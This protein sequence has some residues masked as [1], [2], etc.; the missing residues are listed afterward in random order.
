MSIVTK[1]VLLIILFMCVPFFLFGYFWYTISA[2]TAE[3]NA[4]AFS[5]Q[6]LHQ[7]SE[8]LNGYFR[9][10]ER[11]TY[12]L[13]THPLIQQFLKIPANETY[14]QFAYT[15]RIKEELLPSIIFG[16]AD[17]YNFSVLSKQS[18][19]LSS[20]GGPELKKRNL[21]LL[22]ALVP[23]QNYNVIGIDRIDAAPVLTIMRVFLDT[24]SYKHTGILL[25]DLNLN[26]INNICGRNRLG[27][28][29][30]LWGIDRNGYTVCHPDKSKWGL[31]VAE[32]E[33]KPYQNASGSFKKQDN[34]NTLVTYHR[35]ENT[36]LTLISEVPLQEM[37]RGLNALRDVT[38]IIGILLGAIIF[39][40]LGAFAFSL[41]RSLRNLQRLMK[42]AEIGDLSVTAPEQP[43]NSEMDSV[44]RSFNKM[45]NEI[46]R[47]IE[48]VHR[49]EL[50]QKD[51]Q[52]R[53]RESVL[54]AMQSQI[55]P[56]FLY[57]TLEIINSY[58]IVQNSLPIS[59]MSTALADFFRY[60]VNNHKPVVT[61]KEE[62]AH[63]RTYL[64]IQQERYRKLDMEFD[65]DEEDLDQVSIIRLTLQPLL[66]NVFVHGY[67]RH[68]LR[69]SYIGI[70]GTREQEHYTLKVI[71]KGR[72]MDAA[73]MEQYNR[74]FQEAAAGIDDASELSPFRRIGLWNV[75][76]RLAMQFGDPYGLRIL[77][78]DESGTV[79]EIRLPVGL[80]TVGRVYSEKESEARV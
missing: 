39:I 69:P 9:D 16:R 77:R 2:K 38:I 59:R 75:H 52:I 76:A 58:A 7:T 24:L 46:R 60:S 72:G 5:E 65:L 51:M 27:D 10:L 35:S 63:V 40:S 66:E 47:L 30:F 14:E 25:I 6:L 70:I 54:Q 34:G 49:S 28:T 19:D 79:M 13:L 3:Q 18:V 71:D 50:K 56:H 62:L 57:N 1:L 61:L 67:E 11:E 53:Q 15:K 42:R 48:V 68:R 74:A 22:D 33:L 80:R 45:V 44:N 4:V 17:I 55:N 20:T 21:R 31:K 64:L 23:S 8:H 32:E 73:L 43:F 41:T 26:E 37:N 36:G 12:P 29:G 78:S